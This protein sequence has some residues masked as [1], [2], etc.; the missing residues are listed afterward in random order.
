MRRSAVLLALLLA[1]CLGSRDPTDLGTPAMCGTSPAGGACVTSA[2]CACSLACA[3]STC[4]QVFTPP[5][6]ID[7]NVGAPTNEIR[8]VCDRFETIPCVE[9][10]GDCLMEAA[11]SRAEAEAAGCL[12]EFDATLQCILQSPATCDENDFP[13]F[14][15]RCVDRF[16]A[17]EEC[18]CS[19]SVSCGGT[20]KPPPI[21]DAGTSTVAPEPTC[22]AEISQTC[23]QN[24]GDAAI[25]CSEASTAAGMIWVCTCVQGARVGT[26]FGVRSQDDCCDFASMAADRCGLTP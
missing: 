1:G 16:Q 21:R 19:P 24:S 4:I 15:G 13:D 12:S 6:P 11:E 25:E 26:I 8:Q 9:N 10:E 18:D 20:V 7:V 14:F 2:D 3:N 23:P 5:E 22:F 17:Q